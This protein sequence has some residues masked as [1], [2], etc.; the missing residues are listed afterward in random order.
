MVAFLV[1]ACGGSSD[2]T[3][4]TGSGTTA[5]SEATT[6]DPLKVSPGADIPK[7]TVRFGI[8]PFADAST[9]VIAIREGWFD[10]VGI[11]IEPKPT[12]VPVTADNLVQKIQTGDVD[13]ATAFGPGVI[14]NMGNVDNVRMFGFS[15]AFI[16]S[17]ILASPESGAKPVADL[18][19][20]GMPFD[21]AV[22][23]SLSG[24][25]GSSL[26]I[27]NTGQRRDFIKVYFDLAGIDI[28]DVKIQALPDAQ[29][30][31]LARGGQVDYAS[32]EGA[33]QT[34]QLLNDGWVKLA[35]V[36]DLLEGLPPG[37]PRAVAT[38]GHDGPAATTDFLSQNRETALR[39]LSVMFRTI[40]AVVDHP[41]QYLQEQL[42]YLTSVTGVD[43]T[44]PNLK[45]TQDLLFDFVPFEEQA[46][47]W[48]DVDGPNSYQ[49]VYSA[50]IDSA[51]QSGI[52]PADKDVTPDDAIVGRDFYEQLVA[53]K[54][55]Y[56]KLLAQKGKN[57]SGAKG[58][59]AEQAAE[60]YAARNYL[61]AYRMLKTATE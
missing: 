7:A 45:D 11:D 41:D 55:A 49:S 34:A 53:L 58:Q 37:D 24:L 46:K 32:P 35:T 47:W 8:T 2:S 10:D 36:T 60:Q 15:N 12:G 57:L 17:Y 48:S 44:L 38:V 6:S 30:V 16:G 59:L 33:A 39:F 40:D 5:S 50:Q 31:A 23:Q 13:V 51:K 54:N 43:E 56:D 42:P 18:V 61:D 29:I 28:G 22:K 52:I 1:T 19:K 3:S 27:S 14:Q 25:S 20:Q 26:A 4:D 9:F 21:E